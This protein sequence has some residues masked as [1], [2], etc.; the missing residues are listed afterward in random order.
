MKNGFQIDVQKPKWSKILI[1]LVE[2]A[3]S[4]IKRIKK[5]ENN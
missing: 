4:L 3:L 2:L 5:H 1:N